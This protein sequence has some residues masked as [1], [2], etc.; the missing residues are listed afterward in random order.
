MLV[1]L[2]MSPGF[3]RSRNWLKAHLW[4]DRQEKQASSSLRQALWRIRKAFPEEKQLI[5]ADADAIWLNQNYILGINNE[6][7]NRLELFEGADVRDQGFEEWLSMAR[8]GATVR[9]IAVSVPRLPCVVVNPPV[10]NGITVTHDTNSD[11]L[12]EDIIHLLCNGGLVDVFDARNLKD[13]QSRSLSSPSLRRDA[14]IHWKFQY[15][16]GLVEIGV[17]VVEFGTN[18]VLAMLRRTFSE[19]DLA[20][21]S[22]TRFEILAGV[23]DAIETAAFETSEQIGQPETIF[24]AVHQLMSHS[25]EGQ[26]SARRY[27]EELTK[28]RNH[29]VATAWCAFSYAVGVGERYERLDN[30]FFEKARS[31]CSLA[32]NAAPTNAVVH[33]II[34]HVCGFVFRDFHEASEHHNLARELAPG[35]PIIWDFSAMNALYTGESET[36][37]RFAHQASRLGRHSSL[38]PYYDTSVM[39]CAAA[40]G[41]HAEAIEVGKRVLT[42]IP[43][44]LPVMRHLT[45]SMAALGDYDGSLSMMREV[46]KYD[47]E[48]SLDA[49]SNP[50]YP[51]IAKDSI[52]LIRNAF[53]RT[54]RTYSMN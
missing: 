53:I 20:S 51:I 22:A 41:R 42:K 30:A 48:F 21:G 29:P 28:V 49:L 35:L 16:H 24:K 52:E 19:I 17:R 8:V 27:L 7:S 25:L 50:T 31:L 11:D 32:T 33:A 6:D 36:A 37:Y 10:V 4:S 38:R 12:I 5:D 9:D 23:T 54:G 2:A 43:K 1:L 18:R 45:G 13:D 39:M 3:A 34:G 40:T 15:R 44:I 47:P 14:L 26:Q 46:G